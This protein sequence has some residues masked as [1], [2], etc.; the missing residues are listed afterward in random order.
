MMEI[1]VIVDE[2]QAVVESM[3]NLS[4]ADAAKFGV[5]AGLESP[6]YFYGHPIDINTQM[7]NRDKELATKNK[8]YPAI[9]LRLPAKR[10]PKGGLFYHTINLAIFDVTELNWDAPKRYDEVIRPTLYPLYY[11]LI[12]RL[13][14]RG[15]TWAEMREFPPHEAIDRPHHGVL[16]TQGNKAYQFSR[17]LDAIE[18]VNLKINSKIKQCI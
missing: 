4:A 1:V 3:R 14:K 5:P 7:I 15:F 13:K 9:A 11:L 17:P 12:D 6:Y 10:E 16:E 8:V 2:I 18:L